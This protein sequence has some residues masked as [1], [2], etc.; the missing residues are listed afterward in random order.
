ML[1]PAITD[2]LVAEGLE[3]S[4]AR[5]AEKSG[6]FVVGASVDGS[7]QLILLYYDNPDLRPAAAWAQLD[8]VQMTRSGVE[9]MLGKVFLE[10]AV[11]CLGDAIYSNGKM[12]TYQ[13]VVST[14]GAIDCALGAIT[15]FGADAAA[16]KLGARAKAVMNKVRDSP[17]RFVKLLTDLNFTDDQILR[18][19]AR[20]GVSSKSVRFYIFKLRNRLKLAELPN[21]DALLKDLEA[22]DEAL[23]KAFQE[24]VELVDAW[25]AVGK[26]ADLR[27]NTKF[28]ENISGYS[29]D[30]LKQLD[31]DLLNSKY[32]PSDLFKESPDDVT[33]VWKKLKENPYWASDF[34]KETTD[35]RWLK[36]KDREFF[37]TVTKAGKDF[38]EYVV[39]NLGTLRSKVLNKYPNLDINDYEV[40][41]QVQMKTGVGDEYFV[42][43]LVLVKKNTDEFGQ[44]ILD[45]NNV[46]VLESKLSSR[47][48]LTTP[49]GNALTKVKSSENTFDVRSVSKQSSGGFSIGNSDNLKVDDFIKVSSDGQGGVID[50]IVSL[51]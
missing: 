34:A 49:Q 11:S 20:F 4:S 15:A 18:L 1:L 33:N 50:D 35:A 5:I 24:N 22:G 9:A 17:E 12:R 23:V 21:S 32:S 47:T 19:G 37:K 42:A 38:E 43:D 31:D 7:I 44:I 16:K 8:K 39:Q 36:W 45:K 40:F 41:T 26:H 3:I 29:D 30:L 48:I 46:V 6:E 13:E 51:K 28:L 25:K 14:Q 10:A 2:A 27:T